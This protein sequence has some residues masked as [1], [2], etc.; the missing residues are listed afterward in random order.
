[1]GRVVVTVNGKSKEEV[2]IALEMALDAVKE[3]P[4]QFGPILEQVCVTN[5]GM[6]I[7]K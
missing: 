5:E 2:M 6:S 1:M 3:Y 7:K 4:K